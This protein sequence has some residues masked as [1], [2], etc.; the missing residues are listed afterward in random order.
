MLQRAR[1]G[2]PAYKAMA[3][4]HR[5]EVLDPNV[6]HDVIWPRAVG[7]VRIPPLFKF[8]TGGD[9]TTGAES[10]GVLAEAW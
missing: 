3:F 8:Y 10:A 4:K 6:V 1:R 5:N 9:C 7:R 2:Q